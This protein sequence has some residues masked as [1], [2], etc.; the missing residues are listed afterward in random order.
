[1]SAWGLALQ[2]IFLLQIHAAVA[3]LVEGDTHWDAE[4]RVLGKVLSA[5]APLFPEASRG[6]FVIPSERSVCTFARQAPPT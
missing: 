2:G 3:A 6:Y 4:Y 1:M 5:G